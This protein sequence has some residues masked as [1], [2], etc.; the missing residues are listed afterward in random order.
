MCHGSG[1]RKDKKTNKQTNPKP[2]TYS[3][4]PL[5][6][7]GLRTRHSVCEDVGLI[8]GLT[9]RVRDMALWQD[10]AWRMPAAAAWEL[11]YA[12]GTDQN[13]KEK[14]TLTSSLNTSIIYFLLTRVRVCYV[15]F[16]S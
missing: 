11:P 9:W 16:A 13:E 12:A 3:E 4:F 6:L 14:K 10:V 1:P 7:N 5:W 15:G 8:S 2:P